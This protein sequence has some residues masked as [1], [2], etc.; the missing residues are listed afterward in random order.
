MPDSTR[1]M[2]II[3][4][5]VT[6]VS[7]G[8]GGLAAFRFRDRLHLL[9]GFSSQSYGQAAPIRW[10]RTLQQASTADTA[11]LHTTYTFTLNGVSQSYA[12]AEA[13]LQSTEL[14]A[15]DIA[16]PRGDCSD[17]LAASVVLKVDVDIRMGREK[18]RQWCRQKFHRADI[19]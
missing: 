16:A 3:L 5:S 11:G 8:L 14:D 12:D 19:R 18:G 10:H 7:T 1:F 13:M 9:L 15:I 17:N 4:A 2:P 6:L